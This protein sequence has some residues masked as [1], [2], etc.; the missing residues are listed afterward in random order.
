[1]NVLQTQFLDISVKE[2]QI[3][4][5]GEGKEMA[6]RGRDEVCD[7]VAHNV[8]FDVNCQMIS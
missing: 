8:Q 5:R 2:S 1:M 6:K 4:K 3:G 7:S